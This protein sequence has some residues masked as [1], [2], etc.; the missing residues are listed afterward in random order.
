MQY[1]LTGKNLEITPAMEN[2]LERKLTKLDKLFDENAV[3]Y[4]VMSME[5]GRSKI[6]ITI[7]VKNSTIRSEQT[8]NDI[9]AL[10][11]DAVDAMERQM[12]RYRGKLIDFYQSGQNPNRTFE[13]KVEADEDPIRIV[14]TKRFAVK[15]MDATE[16]CLQMELLGHAFY[17][18]LNSETN[19]VN[20]VYKRNDGAFGLIEPV[21][22]DED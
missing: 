15:P 5:K 22:D 13:E 8:G 3:A 10:I 1:K 20:V 4:T 18:F 12:R 6:E 17:M 11:D 21:L 14:R 7:P 2:I 16:A 19:E 9:Y